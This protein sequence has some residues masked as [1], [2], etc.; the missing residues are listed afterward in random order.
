MQPARAFWRQR[1][2]CTTQL[3]GP[4]RSCRLLFPAP[5]EETGKQCNRTGG[6]SAWSY[7]ARKTATGEGKNEGAK[8]LL[9]VVPD[10]AIRQRFLE[11]IDFGFGEVGFIPDIDLSQLAEPL[12]GTRIGELVAPM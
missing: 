5:Q 2:Q 4:W 6:I 7:A 12:Q 11:L 10:L 3:V 8:L 9:G 1:A